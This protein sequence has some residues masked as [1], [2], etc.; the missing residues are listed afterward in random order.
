MVIMEINQDQVQVLASSVRALPNE[1]LANLWFRHYGPTSAVGAMT[2]EKTERRTRTAKAPVHLSKQ[3]RSK[4][5]RRPKADNA[6][7]SPAEQ[8]VLDYV[9]ANPAIGSAAIVTA[10]G[11]FKETTIKVALRSLKEMGKIGSEGNTR[12]MTYSAAA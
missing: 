8:Q 9:T 7:L 4:A 6:E 1:E 12:N 5:A 11:N 2:V 10:L 3:A